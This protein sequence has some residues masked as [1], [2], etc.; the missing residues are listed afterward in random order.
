M[1]RTNLKPYNH[2]IFEKYALTDSAQKQLS[3]FIS[4]PLKLIQIDRSDSVYI[5]ETRLTTKSAKWVSAVNIKRLA[6]GKVLHY[7]A[8]KRNIRILD[9]QFTVENQS[10]FAKDQFITLAFI[11]YIKKYKRDEERYRLVT[12]QPGKNIVVPTN[13][14]KWILKDSDDD[15][16]LL[17][18]IT[19]I[20]EIYIEEPELTKKN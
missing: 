5:N 1:V 14:G 16:H 8:P 20:Q 7:R 2:L 18:E 4:S 6:E 3:F 11:T 9:V 19:A 17:F 10:R 15:I 12:H 13:N